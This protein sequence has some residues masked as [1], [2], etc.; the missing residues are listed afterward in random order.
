M[1]KALATF[2]R[3]CKGDAC[4][5]E[6]APRRQLC[7]E[8]W[9][10]KQPPVYQADAAIRRLSLIPEAYRRATVDKSQWPDGRRWCGGCQ[11][12]VRKRDCSGSRCKACAGIAAHKSRTKADFGI[13]PEDYQWLLLKQL[14]K[15]A[16]C[17]QRPKSKRMSLDH[18]HKHDACGGKGCRDCVRGLLCARCN[19]ELLAAAHESINILR[20]AV[21]YLET[22]PWKGD[23]E[24]PQWERDEW[25]RL[26]PGEEIPP[27]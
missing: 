2:T 15:C 9:L 27:F 5:Q 21:A 10:A 25:E 6:A 8:C 23:W 4:D 16:I 1:A 11:T 19:H 18:D 7:Y 24:V 17:R 20:N 12:M 3:A 22:P 13:S 26:H 14:G